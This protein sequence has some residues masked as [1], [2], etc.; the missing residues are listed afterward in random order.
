[1]RILLA[2][3]ATGTHVGASLERSAL[4]LGHEARLLDAEQAYR[5]PRILTALAWRMGRRPLG[6][7]RYSQAVARAAA[8]WRPDALVSAGAAPITSAVLKRIDPNVRKAVYLTDDP[9][10]PS[11]RAAWFLRALPEYDRVYTT[12]T[13][14]AD[15]LRR[16]GC[17]HIEY[18]PFAYD[19]A[20]FHAAET[21]AADECGRYA[22]EV[23]FYGGADTERIR[24]VKSLIHQGVPMTLYGGYWDRDPVTR[25]H[26]KGQADPVTLR[27]AVAAARINLCLVRRSNRDGHSMRTF[28]I[29]AMGGYMIVEDTAEHRAIFGED[30][31]CVHYFKGITDAAALIRRMLDLPAERRRM[32][33][34]CRRLITGGQHT[35]TD[36]LRTLLAG[37]TRGAQD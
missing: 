7:D 29:P 30:G 33:A 2:G 20:H 14:L 13:A 11:H 26:W 4:E 6:L 9:W 5:G 27:K 36:R 16:V 15:D 24:L 12:K 17:R 25:A 21:I 10:N 37:L 19:P 8:Q 23:L 32:A 28:E 34:D 18:L 35:Y 3:G 22:S 1:M 31:R